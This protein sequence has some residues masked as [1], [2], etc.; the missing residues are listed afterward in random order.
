MIPAL[1]LSLLLTLGAQ[2][3]VC[4]SPVG[5]GQAGGGMLANHWNAQ[6]PNPVIINSD[7][8]W[9]SNI[10]LSA[11]DQAG[12]IAYGPQLNASVEVSRAIHGLAVLFFNG[13]LGMGSI[14]EGVSYQNYSTSA[15]SSKLSTGL[16]MVLGTRGRSYAQMVFTLPRPIVYSESDFPF[17][18]EESLT[19]GILLLHNMTMPWADSKPGLFN[20]VSMSAL[21]QKNL[22]QQDNI[23]RDHR[24][25]L[26]LSTAVYAWQPLFLAPFFQLQSDQFM[27]PPSIWTH[28]RETRQ[29]VSAS[30][31][32]DLALSIP[33]WE[34]LR[35]R[36]GVPVFS[37]SSMN[38]FP[39]GTQPTAYLILAVNFRGVVPFG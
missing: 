7:W 14:E 32:M 17:D 38:G 19:A 2:A 39:D 24:V 8:N 5:S 23:L 25:S 36:M 31:G 10:Q 1:L 11:Q 18:S 29:L 22:K 35:L 26:H 20:T 33:G 4:C 9:V 3:Q 13:S 34:R 12:N 37:G 21:Y 15:Y 27:A 16:R 6:W 30:V 28:A